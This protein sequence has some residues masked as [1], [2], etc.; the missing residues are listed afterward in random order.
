MKEETLDSRILL[1]LFNAIRLINRGESNSESL[2]STS[3]DIEEILELRIND[4]LRSWIGFS[5]PDEVSGQRI[6]LGGKGRTIELNIFNLGELAL[7]N[8]RV[9]RRLSRCRRRR[10]T[11]L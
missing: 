10:G 11:F 9:D 8:F 2:Q 3:E 5:E 4:R 6:Y 1:E 7:A